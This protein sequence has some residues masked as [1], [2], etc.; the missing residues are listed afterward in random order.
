MTADL[1]VSLGDDPRFRM[2]NHSDDG[3]QDEII[4]LICGTP[5]FAIQVIATHGKFDP[6]L[7]FGGFGLRVGKL[8]DERTFV[9]SLAPCL[10]Q[11]RANGT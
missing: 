5:G 6:D 1:G 2:L 9:S 7:R 11:V 4:F 10:G 3:F 8:A